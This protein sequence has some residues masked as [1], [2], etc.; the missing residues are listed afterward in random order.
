[1]IESIAA[2]DPRTVAIQCKGPTP[3]LL[4]YIQ[5]RPSVMSRALGEKVG[6]DEAHKK[7]SGTGPF[8]FVEYAR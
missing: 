2:R 6:F 5:S 3:G 7:M 1:M 4:S 8:R